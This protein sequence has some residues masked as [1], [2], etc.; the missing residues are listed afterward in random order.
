M[1]GGGRS[2]ST[3]ART[4]GGIVTLVAVVGYLAFGWSFDGSSGIVPAAI[5]IAVATVAIA[6]TLYSRIES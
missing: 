2:E 4:L 1:P 3:V 6:W 5:G